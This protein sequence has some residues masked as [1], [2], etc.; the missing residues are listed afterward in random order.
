MAVG[1]I[2]Q[3]VRRAC[4]FYALVTFLAMAGICLV[5]VPD[6]VIEAMNL[7]GFQRW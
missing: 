1:R 4:V 3:D 6:G 5:L 2:D 7:S